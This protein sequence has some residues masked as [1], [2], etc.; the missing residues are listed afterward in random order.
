MFIFSLLIFCK[1]M[2]RLS[3]TRCEAETLIEMRGETCNLSSVLRIKPFQDD[4]A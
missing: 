1:K 2:E 3:S 4:K